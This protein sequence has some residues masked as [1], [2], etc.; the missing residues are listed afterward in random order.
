MYNRAA[1]SIVGIDRFN[2]ASWEKLDINM[3]GVIKSQDKLKETPENI[4]DVQINVPKPVK[5]IQR[6]RE[7]FW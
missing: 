7:S 5:T 4:Q 3:N 2:A 6:K 1:A